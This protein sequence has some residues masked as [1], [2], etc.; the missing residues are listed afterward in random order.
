MTNVS[1]AASSP[2]LQN[3]GWHR[4]R[5]QFDVVPGALPLEMGA[6]EQVVH[7]KRQVR[8]ESKFV[9]RDLH[10][11]GLGIARVQVYDHEDNLRPVLSGL[12]IGDQLVV[13]DRMEPQTPITL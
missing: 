9:E 11:T 5:I 10:P 8:I 3:V 13:V 7:L 2:H 6:A 1:P 12:A 4:R